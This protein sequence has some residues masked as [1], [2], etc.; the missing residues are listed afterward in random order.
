MAKL[1]R[2][3]GLKAL[4][5]ENPS[6]IQL[7]FEDRQL[8][9]TTDRS[10]F[11]YDVPKEAANRTA[12]VGRRVADGADCSPG[13]HPQTKR[14]YMHFRDATRFAID[15]DVFAVGHPQG[16][17]DINAGMAIF[18]IAS[19]STEVK[20]GTLRRKCVGVA[21][22]VREPVGWHDGR[23]QQARF[24]RPHSLTALPGDDHQ[25]VVTD[26][27]N[28]AV[29]V[30]D[31][32]KGRVASVVYN[33]NLFGQWHEHRRPKPR[34]DVLLPDDDA[35][36]PRLLTRPEAAAVCRRKNNATLCDPKDLL[37]DDATGRTTT[38]TTSR[39]LLSDDDDGVLV[40]T[41]RPCASCWIHYPEECPAASFDSAD[42]RNE[43]SWGSGVSVLAHVHRDNLRRP[44]LRA[45]CTDESQGHEVLPLCC[46]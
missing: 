39:I 14:E 46:K 31:V 9:V 6:G 4:D 20:N 5:F 25:L 34:L 18:Q 37:F 30:V 10:V 28:R 17:G 45:E 33:D 43:S 32:S 21:G 36:T 16:G 15:G 44:I 35:G 27:D 3:L 26:I 23:G 38:T 12:W 22:N 7:L 13:E 24:S 40:W 41:S 19:H 29:R 42:T 8:L 2:I 11:A 1:T